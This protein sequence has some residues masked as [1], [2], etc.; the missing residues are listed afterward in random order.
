[1]VISIVLVQPEAVSV[2]LNVAIPARTPVTTLP[3]TVAVSVSK[4]TQVP[5]VEGVR[6]VVP[7]IHIF[8]LAAKTVGLGLTVIFPVFLEHPDD[9]S[10]NVKKVTP[11]ATPVTTPPLVIVATDPLL[12]VHVPPV[13][14]DKV[15]VLP[16]HIVGGLAVTVGAATTVKDPEAS[17]EQPVLVSVQVKVT[18]PVVKPVT[19]PELLIVATKELLLDQVPPELGVKFVEPNTQMEVGPL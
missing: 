15:V 12:D 17:D 4:L 2:N 8:E 10:V 11:E 1:M 18:V 19:K 14:G 9:V 6:V 5:P 3:L 7:P 13:V 16:A